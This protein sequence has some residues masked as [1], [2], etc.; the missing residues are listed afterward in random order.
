MPGD[1][2]LRAALDSAIRNHL[3][4]R[5]SA[6]EPSDNERVMLHHPSHARFVAMAGGDGD[7]PCLIEPAVECVRCGYCQSYGH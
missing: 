1:A 6:P 5:L 3:A 4:R 2:E 7:S